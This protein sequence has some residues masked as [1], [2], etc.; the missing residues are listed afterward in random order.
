MSL[1]AAIIAKNAEGSLEHTL[2]SVQFVDEI[3]VVVDSSST[4]KTA[5]IAKKYGA[6][7]FERPWAGYGQQK[8]F[9][10]EQTSSE[11]VLFIDA[12]EEVSSE[13]QEAIKLAVANGHH[14]VYWI[15]V[16][17]VFL[18]KPLHRLYGHNPRLLKRSAARWTNS[19]VHEQLVTSDGDD[20]KFGDR[21][22]GLL[23]APLLHYSHPTLASYIQKM[24]QYTTLDARQM[25]STGKLR[26]GK[27]IPSHPLLPL[28]LSVKQFVKLYF[29]R[30]GIL[31]G[32]AGFMWSLMS[33][34]YE[35]EMA[36]KYKRV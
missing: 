36:T 9:A 16:I 11:W 30:R 5:Q 2:R 23:T 27:P 6:I 22:H 34:Y 8:N 28:H 1:S 10:L 17:T 3:V 35:W 26:S 7:V 20:V 21:D 25:R 4:D 15:R 18:G 24:H 12:D 29:Y 13:L 33:A 32:F 31:D 19:F 14:D